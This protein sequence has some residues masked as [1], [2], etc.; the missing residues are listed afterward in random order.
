MTEAM[1]TMEELRKEPD[2]SAIVL[3]AEHAEQ[4][5]K[6]GFDVITNGVLPDGQ[7]YVYKTGRDRGRDPR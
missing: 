1:Q 4:V 2:R 6:M 7:E 5:G 3:S